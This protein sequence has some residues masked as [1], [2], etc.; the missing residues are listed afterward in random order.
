[1]RLKSGN[2]KRSKS[3][4]ELAVAAPMTAKAAKDTAIAST[5]PEGPSSTASGCMPPMSGVSATCVPYV[6]IQS[7][8][9]SS[10]PI[11]NKKE[12]SRELSSDDSPAIAHPNR[13]KSWA[14]M[15]ND[16]LFSTHHASR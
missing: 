7:Q 9:L 14:Y 5:R 8:D 10:P 2:E 12:P 15:V 1:M 13:L 16:Q 11:S 6:S 3:G 4:K